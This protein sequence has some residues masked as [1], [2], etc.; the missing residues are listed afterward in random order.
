MQVIRSL[1]AL[2][3][4]FLVASPAFAQRVEVS[5]G[6]GYVASEGITSNER[7][8]L[9]AVYDTLSPESGASI[10]LTLGVFF[11]DQLQGEFLFGRQAS[12]LV[13][14]GPA[15]KL[16]LAD[17]DIY[18]YLFNLVYNGGER[19]ARVRPFFFGGIGATQ[20]SFGNTLLAGSTGSLDG[21]TRFSTNVGGGVKAYFGPNVGVRVG[22][23]WTPTYITST[24]A[25]V[26][27]D[28]FYGCWA[29]GNA[30]Y[31]NRFETSGGLTVRF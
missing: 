17:L 19:D 28:P 11:N 27:C 3:V 20:Y 18:D 12:R 9:N 26:W 25:G 15:G 7:P 22:V 8:L 23:R 16:P 2:L 5:F 10:N 31:S 6:A 21:E 4:V 24:D 29:V 14:D 30:Q 1:V 13:A